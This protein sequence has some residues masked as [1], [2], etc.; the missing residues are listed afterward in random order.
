MSEKKKEALVIR[1]AR[2]DTD[3]YAAYPIIRQMFPYLDMQTYSR[4][5]FV[6]RATGYRLFL[7]E[8]DNVVVG[9]IGMTNDHNLHDGFVTYIEYVV[10]DGKHRGKGYAR[11]LVE[12]AQERAIEE[13]CNV[14]ELETN[15]DME[16][17]IAMRLYEKIGFKKS[18]YYYCKSLRE[19]QKE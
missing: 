15:N 9:T 4:R 19:E 14:I 6:A 12:F 7:G 17:E 16:A 13:G 3:Y 18:G 11:Q 10:V 1:E 2:S 8:K 5:M